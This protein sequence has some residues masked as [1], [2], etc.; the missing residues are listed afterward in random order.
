MAAESLHTLS[1]RMD[2]KGKIV[3]VRAGID[4]PLTAEGKVVD[5][6]RLR[7]ALPTLNLLRAAG[8]RVVGIRH[9]SRADGSA[10]AS[11]KPVCDLLNTYIPIAWAGGIVGADVEEK[12]RALK[13][14]ELLMLENLRFLPGEKANDEAFAKSLAAYADLYVD[15]AFSVAHREHASI[16][17]IPRFLPS[18]AGQLFMDELDHLSL[19]RTPKAPSLF[20]LGGAKF[21]T[22]LPL[23]EQLLP[24]YDRV[25]VGGALANNFFRARGYEVGNSLVSDIDIGA[26]SLFSS[27]KIL[28]PIDVVALT[29]EGKVVKKPDAIKAGEVIYDAGPETLEML[30]EELRFVATV[31]WNGPL[32]DYERGYDEGTRKFAELLAESNAISIVG[33]GDT[34]ASVKDEKVTERF[35]FLS[36][37]GGA[38]LAFLEQGTLPGIEALRQAP[39]AKVV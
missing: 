4:V 17:G 6:F 10:D 2:L 37:A 13:D 30:K 27:T 31:L 15:D 25:F 7:K 35:T 26:S 20:V 34:V 18:Y 36:T 11:L 9:T 3:L 24:R 14:G 8:A 29:S 39:A 32:G 21:E 33:G 5:D 16:V 19:A 12:V 23:V 28:L 22:K 1:E 38:M